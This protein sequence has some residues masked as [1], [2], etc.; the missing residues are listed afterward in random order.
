M[1]AQSKQAQQL[2]RQL[3][4][5]S[6]VEGAVS[7]EQ[8]TGVLAYVEKHAPANA[9]QVLKIY[10][11][12]I[13]TELAKR[14]AIVEHAGSIDNTALKTIAASLSQLYARPITA[15]AKANPSLIAGLRV[16]VGDDIFESSVASRLEALAAI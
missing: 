4:R 13:A 6:L 8:V 1:S 2:A 10:Q 7:P 16:R 14:Q 12:L 15:T 11:R 3:F 9:I 5:L